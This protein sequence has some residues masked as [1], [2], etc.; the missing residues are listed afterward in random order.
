MKNNE[1][2]IREINNHCMNKAGAGR[3]IPP[4]LSGGVVRGYHCPP[5]GHIKLPGLCFQA[6]RLYMNDV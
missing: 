1:E 3:D 2:A 4:D 5:V 6:V